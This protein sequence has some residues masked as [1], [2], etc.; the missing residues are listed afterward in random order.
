[1]RAERRTKRRGSLVER[2]REERE[3]REATLAF[4]EI[5]DQF[6]CILV[7][8][9]SQAN[10][11]SLSRVSVPRFRQE[12]SRWKG[13]VGGRKE[14]LL[15]RVFLCELKKEKKETFFFNSPAGVS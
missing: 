4:Q 12:R 15:A 7:F 3:L 13:G 8:L 6:K 10:L 2:E 11:V 1:M 9:R 14:T 5:G